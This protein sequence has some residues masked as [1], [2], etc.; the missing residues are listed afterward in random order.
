MH[1]FRS[2]AM[3]VRCHS[4]VFP[5]SIVATTPSPPAV[6]RWSAPFMSIVPLKGATHF[7]SGS[8]R[9]KSFFISDSS[10]ESEKSIPPKLY[11]LQAVAVWNDPIPSFNL[12][13]KLPPSTDT[14]SGNPS[15]LTSLTMWSSF[16][17]L[18]V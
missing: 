16:T 18:Q 15:P 8:D 4:W 11:P 12:T 10:L 5:F 6:L 1:G 14:R 7:S 2:D 3:K 17:W 9:W 13:S